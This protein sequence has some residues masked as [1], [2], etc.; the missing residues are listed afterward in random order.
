MKTISLFLVLI[1]LHF[2]AQGQI[3][4]ARLTANGLTRS[5]RCF[6]R[7][8]N[9]IFE[10]DFL[11]VQTDSIPRRVYRKEDGELYFKP[12]EKEE[13]VSAYFKN[14]MIKTEMK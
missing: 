6:N 4:K 7:S 9:E 11:D 5:N 14:D 12:Y 2:S 8:D 10:G 1:V 13:K 3:S